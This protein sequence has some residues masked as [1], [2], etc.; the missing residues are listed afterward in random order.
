MAGNKNISFRILIKYEWLGTRLVTVIQNFPEVSYKLT[1][2][3]L[4]HLSHCCGDV[5]VRRGILD[6]YKEC[7]IQ[8]EVTPIFHLTYGTLSAWRQIR[9]HKGRCIPHKL[10]NTILEVFVQHRLVRK[11]KH[12]HIT[13]NR[14]WMLITETYGTRVLKFK[15]RQTLGL[16][17]HASRRL[18]MNKTNR[19]TVNFQ[20]LLMAQ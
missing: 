13:I 15:F 2:A 11:S 18:L 3:N 5:H 12:L 14:L 1:N 16:Y 20:F 9:H 8:E 4:L 10:N 17:N 19:C 7:N 6:S